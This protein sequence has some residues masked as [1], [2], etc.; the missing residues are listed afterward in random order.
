MHLHVLTPPTFKTLRLAFS[1]TKILT[2]KYKHLIIKLLNIPYPFISLCRHI[3]VTYN[4][5]GK[6]TS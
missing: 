6:F 2:I 1:S 3:Q 5:S 4:S